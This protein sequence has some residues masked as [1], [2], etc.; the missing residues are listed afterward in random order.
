M[1]HNKELEKLKE[2]IKQEFTHL[3]DKV[4][5]VLIYGSYAS[6]EQ[7]EKSDVDIC[8]VVGDNDKEKIKQ[9]IPEMLKISGKN[10]RY[11]IR[12]FEIMPLYMKIEVINNN[13]PV[14]VKDKT[15]LSYYFYFYKK[16]W[17]NQAITRLKKQQLI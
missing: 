3:F 11:D 7:S 10:E 16:L 5:A 13:I 2:K 15:E 14:Y 9:I 4:L 8:I 6:N 12:I 17:Q 1:N